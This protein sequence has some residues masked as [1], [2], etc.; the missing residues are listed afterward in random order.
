MSNWLIAV[1]VISVCVAAAYL[2][3]VILKP[4]DF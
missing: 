3:Y 2:L 4:E 1:C